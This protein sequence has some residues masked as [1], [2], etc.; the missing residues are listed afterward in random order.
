VANAEFDEGDILKLVKG[1]AA[2]LRQQ[3]KQYLPSSAPLSAEQG[4]SMAGFFCSSLLKKVRIVELHGK[5]MPALPESLIASIAKPD[6]PLPEVEHMDSLT[7]GDLL[8]F[9]DTVADRRLFHAL[10]HA[11]QFTM[12]GVEPYFDLYIKAFLK[13]RSYL[14]VPLEMHAFQLDTKY[15]A[16]PSTVFSVEDDI[17]LWYG[18]G[19]YGRF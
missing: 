1:F 4:E 3:K 13:N 15:T 17:R 9:R 19:R 18:Q 10:V 11:A 6:L 7:Y 16:A 14:T 5:P 12:L 2:Y 8:L